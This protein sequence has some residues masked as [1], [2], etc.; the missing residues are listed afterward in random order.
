MGVRNLATPP[1]LRLADVQG[2]LTETLFE[3]NNENDQCLRR[4]LMKLKGGRAI[5]AFRF[6]AELMADSELWHRPGAVLVPAPSRSGVDHAMRLAVFLAALRG[7]PILSTLQRPAANWSQ[8]RLPKRSRRGVPMVMNMNTG[9][10]LK[11]YKEIIFVD[12]IVTTGATARKA[13]ETLRFPGPFRVWALA[14]R[15][16]L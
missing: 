1:P 15:S 11:P 14:R 6:L 5:E 13:F 4:L 7:L 8:K 2:F 9:D 10:G 12:D 16:L 3:W